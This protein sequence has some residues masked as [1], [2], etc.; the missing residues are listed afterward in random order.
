MDCRR[1][2]TSVLLFLPRRC[3]RPSPGLARAV[4]G[5]GGASSLRHLRWSALSRPWPPAWFPFLPFLRWRP[6]STQASACLVGCPYHHPI[7]RIRRWWWFRWRRAAR[8]G[9]LASGQGGGPAP[10]Q[11]CRGR[12]RVAGS[13]ALAAAGLHFRPDLAGEVAADASMFYGEVIGGFGGVP[14]GAG[15]A[16][17]GLQM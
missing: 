11:A 17:G 15:G 6:S 5:G 2:R 1:D 9:F 13:G 10:A 12:P 16:V 8:S 4:V 14:G 3:R 7:R